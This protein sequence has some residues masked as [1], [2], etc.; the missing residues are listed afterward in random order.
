VDRE[1]TVYSLLEAIGDAFMIELL[2]NSNIRDDVLSILEG[3][4]INDLEQ[5]LNKI[6]RY[7]RR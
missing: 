5:V 7:G 1:Q 6:K 4:I 2:E 3:D